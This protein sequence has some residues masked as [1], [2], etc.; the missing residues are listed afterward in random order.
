MYLILPQEPDL[1]ATQ[2]SLGQWYQMSAHP[3]VLSCMTSPQRY[4]FHSGKSARCRRGESWTGCRETGCKTILCQQQTMGESKTLSFPETPV[5]ALEKSGRHLPS[6]EEGREPSRGPH[7]DSFLP[8]SS[9][10]CWQV[11]ESTIVFC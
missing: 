2:R 3:S 5:P 8:K 10:L 6:W 9:W 4:V 1:G 11:V 7:A